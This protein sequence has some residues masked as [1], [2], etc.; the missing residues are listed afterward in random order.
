MTNEDDPEDA[1]L[2][3]SLAYYQ[4]Q[5]DQKWQELSDIRLNLA[6]SRA[7]AELQVL[8]GW[9]GLTDR[10]Q[11]LERDHVIRLRTKKLDAYDLGYLQGSLRVLGIMGSTR[12]LDERALAEA[13]KRCQNLEAELAELRDVLS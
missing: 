9:K 4:H 7:I 2:E 5:F 10:L 13:E 11:G 1:K 3:D 8:P 12:P 6:L